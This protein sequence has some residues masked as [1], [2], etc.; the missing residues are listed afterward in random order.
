M[1]KNLFGEQVEEPRNRKRQGHMGVYQKWRAQNS[2]RVS[3]SNYY[4]CKTCRYIL[5][6]QNN[7]KTYYKC[8]LQ[9][10]SSS[11]ASDIRISYICKKWE[12]LNALGNTG[13]EKGV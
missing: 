1:E 12:G 7:G 9:G 6:I 4:R 10:M 2:Y 13:K 5:K 11:E 3:D 8:E